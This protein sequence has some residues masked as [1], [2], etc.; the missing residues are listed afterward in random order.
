MKKLITLLIIGTLLSSCKSMKKISTETEYLRNNYEELG[1][2]RKTA[3]DSVQSFTTTEGA[4]LYAVLEYPNRYTNF[5]RHKQTIPGTQIAAG[6]DV[7]TIGSWYR[8]LTN[9]ITWDGKVVP[10]GDSFQAASGKRSFTGTGV[11]VEE[12]SEADVYSEVIID[13]PIKCRRVGNVSTGAIDVGTDGKPLTNGHAEY[14]NA[15]NR[16]RAEFSIFAAYSQKKW[17][18]RKDMFK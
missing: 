9:S 2:S 3:V 16:P 4:V 13:A 18:M 6:T 7:L 11:V 1:K 8:V 5:I 17:V 15:T 14:Y 10:V 12:F